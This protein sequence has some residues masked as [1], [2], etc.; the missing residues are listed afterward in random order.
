[1]YLEPGV[2]VRACEDCN[3]ES[4]SSY[5]LIFVRRFFAWRV[6]SVVWR[7]RLLDAANAGLF[8]SAFNCVWSRLFCLLRYACSVSMCASWLLR[9][10]VVMV[11]WMSAW[12]RVSGFA[13]GVLRTVDVDASASS[14]T[15]PSGERLA[16]SFC[17]RSVSLG[18]WWTYR[19]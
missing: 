19:S 5:S 3:D 2:I 1:M 4:L 8:C 7:C 17:R 16:W 6:C 15:A 9:F 10:C 12:A 11:C 14:A 18:W 13:V